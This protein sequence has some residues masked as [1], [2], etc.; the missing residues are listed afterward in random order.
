M[1]EERWFLHFAVCYRIRYSMNMEQ[2]YYF[3]DIIDTFFGKRLNLE[4][5]CHNFY[6]KRSEGCQLNDIK[7]RSNIKI[8]LR[9]IQIMILLH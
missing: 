4:G 6:C 3:Q 7:Q 8:Q 9:M 1:R 2:K 5:K